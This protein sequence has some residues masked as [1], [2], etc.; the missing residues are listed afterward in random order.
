MQE[1][2]EKDDWFSFR[3]L[4]IQISNQNLTGLI[5]KM[6]KLPQIDFNLT[7]TTGIRIF[8]K[9]NSQS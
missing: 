6:Q 5:M 9:K 3:L 2:L 7:Q 4:E 8:L 1:K